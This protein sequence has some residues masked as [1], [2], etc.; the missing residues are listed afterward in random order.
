MAV[1]ALEDIQFRGYFECYAEVILVSGAV[2]NSIRDTPTGKNSHVFVHPSTPDTPVEEHPVC[3][4]SLYQSSR[5][6]PL[7][8]K[9]IKGT[10]TLTERCQIASIAF[11]VKA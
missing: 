8:R 9:K 7:R 2:R 1:Q 3:F 11:V 5:L 4:L 10:T 6:N